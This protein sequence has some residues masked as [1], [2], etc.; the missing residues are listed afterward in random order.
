MERGLPTPFRYEL[1]DTS[2]TR[3]HHATPP[4]LNQRELRRF[5][6][7]LRQTRNALRSRRF[8]LLHLNCSFTA[9]ATPRNF[10][11][12]VIAH[13]AGIPYV[14]HL[15]GTF[16]LPR[17]GGL[18]SRLYRMAYRRM[19]DRAAAILALGAPS[20]R[21]IL[22]LG[23]FAPKTTWLMPNFVD[24]AKVPKAV[25][26]RTGREPIMQVVFT[27]TLVPAK[28]IYTILDLAERLD[29]VNFQLV[30][31]GP[32]TVRAA[33][34]QAVYDRGLADC[35]RVRTPVANRDVWPLL[36]ESDIFLFPSAHRTEAFPFS[37]LEAM[38]AGL[39][40]VASAVGAIPEMIDIPAGGYLLGPNDLSGYAVALA[41]LRD[42]PTERE[43]MG[44]YNRAKAMRDYDYDVVV[45]RL[46]AV[47]RET[48]DSSAG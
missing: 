7:I 18:R 24:F 1:I 15:H 43:R 39:P 27:G 46:C 34:M 4:R 36:A 23:D 2:V 13:R 17:R 42:A 37:V 8:A 6:H 45:K 35:V 5:L 47:Y 25:R 11:T 10:L 30:G 44:Q 48:L 21:G 22:E 16:Q 14:M 28:G 9:T 41:R 33:F 20:Y 40:V 3:R 38:A 31:D 32:P 29:D 26:R 19:F 12:A